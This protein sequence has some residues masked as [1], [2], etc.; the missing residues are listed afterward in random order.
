VTISAELA[1]AQVVAEVNRLP[2]DTQGS[3][4]DGE[5]DPQATRDAAT[6]TLTVDDWDDLTWGSSGPS[7]RGSSVSAVLKRADVPGRGARRL[8]L[9]AKR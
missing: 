8:A 7:A 4:S 6:L 1:E 3:G 9:T 5:E 2:A